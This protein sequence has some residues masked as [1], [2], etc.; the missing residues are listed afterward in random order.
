MERPRLKAHFNTEIVDGDKVFLVAEDQHYMVRGADPVALLPYL[1][2][3]QTVGDIVQALHGELSIPRVLTALR[4]YEA[5]GHLAE[6]RPELPDQVLA[7]WD[8]QGIDPAAVVTAAGAKGVTLVALGSTDPA[9]VAEALRANGVRVAAAGDDSGEAGGLAIVLADDYLD[10]AL[11]EFNDRRIADGR[12]WLLARPAGVTAWLGPLMQPGQTGCWFCMAQRISE[13]RQVERYLSGKRGES[14]PR[15]ATAAALPTGRQALAGLLAT[16][17][18]RFL[19]TGESAALAGRMV[20]LDLAALG[21]TEHTLVRR[22]QCPSCG[23]PAITA[24]R[25]PKVVLSPG[26]ARHTTDG[27]YRT[28]PPQL[29]YERLKH[30]V[31]PHLGAITKLGAHDAIGNGITY[32]FTAGHNFAMV[33]DNMDLLRRNMRGQS[34]GK[35]RSETQ[36]KVSA[37]CE[38]IE[39]YS[40]VW[41]GGEPVRRAAYEELDPAVALHMDELLNFSPAQFA[42][43]DAWNADPEHRIH[44]VPERFRTDLELDWS[45]AWSLTHDSERL[46][47]TGYAYYGHPDLAR[48]FYCVGDSNGGASGNTL[49]E[50]ILQGFCEVVERDAVAVWWYNRLRRPAFDLDSLEDPYIDALRRFYAGMDRDLWVLDI[51]S[52]LGIPTFAALSHRRHRVEDIMVGFGAHPDPAIA[53]MR[54][55]T[56]VNQFLPFVERRDADGNTEYRTDDVETLKWCRQARLQDEPWLLPDPALPAT[57]LADHPGLPGHDLASHIRECVA[58]AGKAGV[59]VIVLDQT[60]PDLDLNVVKVIAPGMR[61]FWRRLAPG[62]LYDVPVQLGLRDRPTPEEQVNPWNVFF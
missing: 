51:T 50:A 34:G 19:A 12:P 61:H 7:F 42:G 55:L 43:R 21:T 38:A 57:T 48:H 27:G 29:T 13:N 11:A 2:G 32:A 17:A 45:T 60:Q 58:R 10:P 1:D 40:A 56:E 3:R 47:P 37:L 30:H 5:A 26:A 62:R 16:E 23:D 18:A 20:T 49:E 14:V 46:V 8:A 25:S 28:L 35:G 54:A 31:S 36:A 24:Q 39:R 52:D 53:V 4:R 41:R 9:P 22:P 15:H 44:L 33:N 6:G 59:E